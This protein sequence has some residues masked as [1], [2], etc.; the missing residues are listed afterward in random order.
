MDTISF[1]Y[2]DHSFCEAS[3][4]PTGSPEYINS[5]T[6]LYISYI[7]LFG[8]LYNSKKND[9]ITMAYASLVVNGI[10]SAMYHYTNVIGWGL[11]DR[12][13]MI[14][15]V[16]YSYNFFLSSLSSGTLTRIGIITYLTLLT[17]VTGLH[18]ETGFNILFGCFLVSLMFL[19]FIQDRTIGFT[20][21]QWNF[22]ICGIKYIILSGTFWILTEM[23][24]TSFWFMKFTFGH[25]WW[26]IGVSTGGYYL[27]LTQNTDF[28]STIRYK[29]GL[30]YW[31]IDHAHINSL[32]LQGQNNQVGV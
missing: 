27:T 10:C 13:S 26:H 29:Y 14:M 22:G 31:K 18:Y 4:Y 30:P 20:N 16:V 9:D 1:D 24:C 32:K 25:A 3:L 11:M 7:G 6:S 5:I 19:L 17:T 12:F 21:E 15:I 28:Y 8:L 2:Y 23:L